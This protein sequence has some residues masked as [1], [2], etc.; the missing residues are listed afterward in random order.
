MADYVL[1]MFDTRGHMIRTTPI[2][3]FCDS[4]AKLI[5]VE[6]GHPH[7]IDIRD[8]RRFVGSVRQGFNAQNGAPWAAQLQPKPGDRITCEQQ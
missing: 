4:E 3:A 6:Q 7:E 1:Q 2:E 5:A 8:G